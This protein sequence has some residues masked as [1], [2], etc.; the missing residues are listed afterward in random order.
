MC[1]C[2]AA[3]EDEAGTSNGCSFCGHILSV[4]NTYRCF[5]VVPKLSLIPSPSPSLSHFIAHIY[6]NDQFSRAHFAYIAKSFSC[7][8]A[9]DSILKITLNGFKSVYV[10]VSDAIAELSLHG[11]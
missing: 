8:F 3:A 7:M 10:Y 11:F 2:V 1:A 9:T 6:S 4:Y 5:S